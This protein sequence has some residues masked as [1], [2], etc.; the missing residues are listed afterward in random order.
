MYTKNEKPRKKPKKIIFCSRLGF[1]LSWDTKA[2]FGF[3]FRRGFGGFS[4]RFPPVLFGFLSSSPDR[5]SICRC[6]WAFWPSLEDNS[7]GSVE[8]INKKASANIVV[9]ALG[10]FS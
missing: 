5:K 8:Q 3:R 9:T 10:V 4:F 2:E 1:E 7:F 6:S